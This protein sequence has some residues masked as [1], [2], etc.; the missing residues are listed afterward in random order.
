MM[1][2]LLLIPFIATLWVPIYDRW[3]PDLA[4]IPFFYWYLFA[5][6]FIASALTWIV[7]RIDKA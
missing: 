6:V 7:D 2:W 3:H 1:K 5:W 4:G